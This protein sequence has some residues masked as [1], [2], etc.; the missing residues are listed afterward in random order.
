L[1][2]VEGDDPLNPHCEWV[3]DDYADLQDVRVHAIVYYG[4]REYMEILNPYLER[5]LKRNGG[6]LDTVQFAL[7]KYTHDDLRY[8]G[9]LV[10]RNR[11]SY[12]VPMIDGGGWDVIWRLASEPKAIYV[13][14]DDDIVYIADGAIAEL[15][16]EKLRGR[17]LF[18]SANVVNHGILSA[19]HQELA[20][21]R[22][23][24]KP[25]AADS[26]KQGI[27]FPPWHFRGDVILDPRFRIEHT[28]YSDCIWR[29]WDCA[30]L[31]HEVLLHRLA[32][33]TSCAFDF[34][35][36]DLHAHGYGTMSDGL[37]RSIDW[38]TNF[39]AF[40][41]EDFSDINWDGVSNDDEAEMSTKHPRRRNEHAAALGRA[42]VSHFTFSSQ[43]K[44]LRQNTSLVARY[45]ALARPL[46]LR[47]AKLFYEGVEQPRPPP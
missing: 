22:W 15:V 36:Y 9:P 31:A 8:L 21:L 30:A 5:D 18:V 29:R 20:Q 17:F 24:A 34:G 11:G 46:I 42:L 47:N 7:V 39:F 1:R 27:P 19:V 4:R 35:M 41:T 12:I 3:K 23:L 10:A 40:A 2:R 45:L 25:T 33:G 6:V 26:E 28:F 44:G 14:I 37:G 32:D 43:E 13:K 38:N 16:R